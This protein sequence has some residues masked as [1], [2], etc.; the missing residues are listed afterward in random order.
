MLTVAHSVT[1]SLAEGLGDHGNEAVSLEKSS[2]FRRQC[3]SSKRHD[4]FTRRHGIT[5]QQ[6]RIL[7]KTTTSTSNLGNS[8]YL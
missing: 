3:G 5:S 6:I 2:T 8:L 4:P 7:G 1:I